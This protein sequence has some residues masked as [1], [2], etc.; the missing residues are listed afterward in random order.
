MTRRGGEVRVWSRPL[1]SVGM[2]SLAR[3]YRQARTLVDAGNQRNL[4]RGFTLTLLLLALS[5][6]LVGFAL[7][8]YLASRVSRPIRELTAALSELASGNLAVRVSVDREDEIGEAMRAFNRTAEE[9]EQNRAR[10]VYLAQLAS[11]QALARKMAHEL[12]NSLTP[13]RLT[14]EEV[15]ARA[16]ESDPA[17]IQQAAQIVGEEVETLERRVRAFSEFAAEPPVR[18]GVLDVNAVVEERVAFLRTGSAVH[19]AARSETPGGAHRRGSGEGCADEPARERC[20]GGG[21]GRRGAGADVAG[22]WEGGGGGARLGS[23]V[24]RGRAA[25]SVRAGHL[26]QEGWN[27]IG[28]LNR[29]QERPARGR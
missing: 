23:R 26:L 27:G 16:G 9:L 15:L 8:A 21:T 5:V 28:P 29:P 1:G 20:R 6:W 14:M 10:L 19:T 25:V 22:E 4:R 2:E 7:L 18:P 3:Q 17:F 12:K 11:W 24:E 13:I